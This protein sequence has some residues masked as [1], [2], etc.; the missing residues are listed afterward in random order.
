[1]FTLYSDLFSSKIFVRKMKALKIL[2]F[3]KAGPR[4]SLILKG[5]K[6]FKSKNLLKISYL[7][8]LYLERK[9]GLQIHPKAELGDNVKFPHPTSIV[10]GAGVKIEDDVKIFQN[11]T[12]GGARLG[13]A[14]ES[15]YPIIKKG[16]V[17][18]S[19]AVLIGNIEVG[20]NCVIGAN[21]V[22]NKNVP[23][24]HV[25]VGVPCKVIKKKH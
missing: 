12:L 17:I 5:Y 22:V 9:Y 15:K 7:V 14:K 16:T 1:M 23:S 25:A 8:L 6:Y 11:V 19:G 2:L 4:V 21:A 24:N 18:F 13:D 10:I 3:G 20:E